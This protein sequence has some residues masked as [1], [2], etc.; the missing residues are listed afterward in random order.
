MPTPE[1][2]AMTA[3]SLLHFVWAL[4]WAAG[5]F[6]A[7]AGYGAAFLRGLRMRP[8]FALSATAG[9]APVILV[10]G[11]LNLLHLIWSPVL[12]AFAGLGVG[13]AIWLLRWRL[14]V[15]A[16]R[17]LG[18]A[19]FLTLVIVSGARIASTVH[20][21]YYQPQDD[22]NYYIAAP[23]KMLA[24]HSFAADPYS[25]RRI[26]ASIGG[27]QFLTTLILATQPLESEAMAD[28]TLGALLLLVLALEIGKEFELTP[29]QTY[30]FA[31]LLMITPQIRLNLTFVVLPSALFLGLAYLAAQR[32][33]ADHPAIQGLLLGATVGAISSLKSNY[34]AHGVIFILILGLMLWWRRGG[35]AAGAVVGWAAVGCFVVMLPWMVASETTCGTW[36]YPL[37]GKGLH[38]SAYG[39]YRMPMNF[40]L[41]ILL[42]KVLP[43]SLPILALFGVEWLV[44]ER[45]ERSHSL[46]AFALAAFVGSS[47]VG[48]ATGGD[49][50]R[51]YNFPCVL[52]AVSLLFVVCA[53]RC[54]GSGGAWRWVQGAVAL[55][56][57]GIAVSVGRNRLTFE[58]ARL[59][60]ELHA[61]LVDFHL[62]DAPLRERYAAMQ[63]AIPSDGGVLTT[64]LTPFLLDFSQRNILLADFPGDASPK[65]GWPARQGGDALARFLLAH[66][67]RYLAYSYNE[68]NLRAP[69]TSC[70]EMF[71]AEDRKTMGDSSVSALIRGETE[72]GYDARRQY[73]ELAR[74]RRHVYDDGK[75]YVL[76]LAR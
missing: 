45:D 12:M 47:V 1:F 70:G 75:I 59:P 49:S 61:S 3:G 2:P 17:G 73:A 63:R 52:P 9:F 67:V 65:P 46:M 14:P 24:M 8:T 31:L 60:R 7:V 48:M 27:N 71:E 40:D 5:I 62:T 32:L 44:C 72:S 50:L 33:T 39:N 11:V 20:N 21:P 38:F 23:E 74:T 26:T 54:N 56:L 15:L 18:G 6:V 57:A 22:L 4:V 25:E 37:L 28:W 53:R 43:F 76:D 10:G 13:L 66:G 16:A 29:L 35:R 42:R 36:F 30:L 41:H 64:L 68:C 34:I 58:Y 19:V 55:L 51:R 69:F